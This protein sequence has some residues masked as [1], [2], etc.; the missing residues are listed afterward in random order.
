L[1]SP[2]ALLGRFV[3][4]HPRLFVLTGAGVSTASGIPGYRDADGN[5]QRPAPV[6]HQAFTGS[7]TVRRRYWARSMLGWPMI[8][9]AMPNAAHTALARL[10]QDGRVACVVTQNVDG[11]HQRAGSEAVIDLHGRLDEVACLAC[12]ALYARSVTQ[13]AMQAANPGFADYCAAIAPDGDAE[14]DA[15]FHAFEVPCCSACGGLLKPNVVFYGAN[16][17]R[18]RVDAALAALD[19]A[20]AMLVVGSSLMVYSSYRFCERAHALGKPIA[21]INRGRTRADD[22]FALKA[23]EDCVAALTALVE[24]MQGGAGS[25]A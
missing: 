19:G 24:R 12:G 14:L 1:K 13:A 9:A 25:S 10:E 20:D 16:V 18:P 5:W 4:D 15:G 7:E 8:A 2:C 21:A 11:L 6:T 3:C 17:P 23:D 22:W